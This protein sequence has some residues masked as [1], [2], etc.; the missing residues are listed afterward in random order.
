VVRRAAESS[1]VASPASVEPDP[2]VSIDARSEQAPAPPAPKPTAKR[3]DLGGVY[4]T[5]ANILRKNQPA[6]K[7]GERIVLT[8]AE[9][10]HYLKFDAITPVED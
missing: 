4:I 7:P 9:A 1:P 6:W 2:T 5:Q 10:R 8:D 3:R